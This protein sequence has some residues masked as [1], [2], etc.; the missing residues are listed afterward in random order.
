VGL[1]EPE[2]GWKSGL[3][4]KDKLDL[5]RMV[6]KTT[7][8]TSP[9]AEESVTPEAAEVV[10]QALLLRRWA[11]AT[12]SSKLWS[13]VWIALFSSKSRITVLVFMVR[14]SRTSLSVSIKFFSPVE[15][16][17]LFSL[18]NWMTRPCV[19]SIL[20]STS[21]VRLRSFSRNSFRSLLLPVK[22]IK[23]FSRTSFL[24]LADSLYVLVVSYMI[25]ISMIMI[26]PIAT[27]RIK[28]DH[29]NPRTEVQEEP[30]D[31]RSFFDGGEGEGSMEISTSESGKSK[32]RIGNWEFS[33]TNL[34]QSVTPKYK[35]IQKLFHMRLFLYWDFFFIGYTN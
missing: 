28:L 21:A 12:D 22:L 13:L 8:I 32:I 35:I 33:L 18:D 31:L 16:M 19:S 1:K 30:D 10:V 15:Y 5:Q 25:L 27:V 7:Q 6:K 29:L 26:I 14:A 20:S 17:S 2:S 11:E 4:R 3:F 9:A 23:V 34:Q 24:W